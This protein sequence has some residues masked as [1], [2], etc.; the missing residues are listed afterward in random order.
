[1]ARLGKTSNNEYHPD[2]VAAYAREINQLIEDQAHAKAGQKKD[3]SQTRILKDA[4]TAFGRSLEQLNQFLEPQVIIIYG[5]MS[6]LID[7]REGISHSL[8]GNNEG[9]ATL[10]KIR[11]GEIS[12]VRAA[13]ILALKESIYSP[14]L[15]F[16]QVCETAAVSSLGTAAGDN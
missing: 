8:G 16:E 4:G 5:S 11:Y 3:A 13:G 7:Y 14:T 6:R 12:A 15:D 9:K 10:A 1:L 2:D